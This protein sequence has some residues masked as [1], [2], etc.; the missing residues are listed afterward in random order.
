MVTET[1]DG[2]NPD[3]G[4][5]EADDMTSDEDLK[6]KFKHPVKELKDQLE[7]HH[8]RAELS[9]FK[10]KLGKLTNVFNPNHR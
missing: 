1:H 9:H 8:L 2:E 5:D 3:Q 4:Y 6:Y 7:N 10:H